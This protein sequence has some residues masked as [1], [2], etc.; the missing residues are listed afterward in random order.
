MNNRDIKRLARLQRQFAK[1]YKELPLCGIDAGEVHITHEAMAEIMKLQQQT[2]KVTPFESEYPFKVE[3]E[4]EGVK[5][6][7][8]FTAEEFRLVPDSFQDSR[9]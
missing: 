2:T 1:A 5:F 3:V 6:M 7:A 9:L 4:L 8:L